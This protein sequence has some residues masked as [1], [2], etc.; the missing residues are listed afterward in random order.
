MSNSSLNSTT[1]NNPHNSNT[2]RS[3]R[4]LNTTKA[5]YYRPERSRTSEVVLLS[6]GN[7]R[8]FNS[9]NS[10]TINN[11]DWKQ[12]VDEMNNNNDQ[13]LDLTFNP[14][15]M[16]SRTSVTNNSGPSNAGVGIG[17]NELRHQSQQIKLMN[18]YIDQLAKTNNIQVNGDNNIDNR[19]NGTRN[20]LVSSD[21]GSHYSSKLE[22]AGLKA[23]PN[24]QNTDLWPTYSLT[25]KHV[26][27]G[28]GANLHI[29]QWASL[30]KTDYKNF[31][32]STS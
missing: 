2:N 23:E 6:D 11:K 10:S 17:H 30:Y 9:K 4:T 5:V 15:M 16:A 3:T 20:N 29:A 18:Q 1:T 22:L 28:S 27:I 26:G 25:S 32:P 31:K 13:S 8:L 24:V 19:T 7:G 12:E 21:Y 14:T